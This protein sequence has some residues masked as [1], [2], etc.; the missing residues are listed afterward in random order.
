[1]VAAEFVSVQKITASNLSFGEHMLTKKLIKSGTRIGVLII[2]LLLTLHAFGST[3]ILSDGSII[4]GEII[5]ETET[6]ISIQTE[7][8]T[9]TIPRSEIKCYDPSD[10]ISSRMLVNPET[11][12]SSQKHNSNEADIPDDAPQ[13]SDSQ[14][15]R[16]IQP[17]LGFGIG[18]PSS[19]QVESVGP[20]IFL[21]LEFKEW[22]AI[23]LKFHAGFYEDTVFGF[24]L[25]CIFMFPNKTNYWKPYLGVGVY[26]GTR[27]V[28]YR[29]S[30]YYPDE[31][32]ISGFGSLC[33]PFALLNF[34]TKYLTLTLAAV[35]VN[36]ILI[37]ID[38]EMEWAKIAF[39]F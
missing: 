19:I 9:L 38:L 34:S 31:S 8:F 1:M 39:K 28:T 20:S 3:I 17:A 30:D 4:R 36:L 10:S 33:F 12:D 15:K 16:K 21:N 29:Y 6:E 22:L 26:A 32:N 27:K 2:L 14:T 7:A 18:M 37:D 13:I 35:Q 5:Q 25:N 11:K 24:A 23:E